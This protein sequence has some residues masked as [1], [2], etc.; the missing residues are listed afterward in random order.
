MDLCTN[1]NTVIDNFTDGEYLGEKEYF[2]NDLNEKDI[3]YKIGEFDKNLKII[4]KEDS[5]I[6][7]ISSSAILE[8]FG[9][10]Y[11]KNSS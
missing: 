8:V 1:D 10:D 9:L 4:V 6:N 7:L 5:K 11:K 2:D 3:V